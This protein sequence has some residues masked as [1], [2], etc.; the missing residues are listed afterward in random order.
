MRH[1]VKHSVLLVACLMTSMS[2]AVDK[3]KE[4][5]AQEMGKAL[6]F[7]ARL[8]F[9]N[10]ISCATCHN[11]DTAFADRRLTRAN[12]VASQGA[13]GH[14]FGDRN[15]PTASYAAFSP[16][17]HYDEKLKQYVGGQFWD[18]R[19]ETLANQ[20]GGPPVNPAEMMMPDAKAVVDRLKEVPYYKETLEAIYG[21]DVWNETDKAYRAVT[22]T[23]EAFEK[24]K[25]FSTFDSKY[26]RFLKGEYELTIEED[27]GRT[28][29]FSNNNVNC[30]TCHLINRVVEDPKETFTNFQYRNIGV[31][32]N[33]KLIEVH[34][35][36]NFVDQGLAANPNVKDKEAQRGKFKV[37]TLRN[38]AVT[39]PYMHNGVF[40]H[41]RTV[42]QFYNKY[43]DPK[44]NINPETGLP[45]APPEV[46]D[47]IALDELKAVAL[48]P[49]KIDALVAFLET[50]TDKRYEPLLEEIKKQE[51]SKK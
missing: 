16:R 24:T 38:V 6:F 46:E 51:A 15:A 33:P 34:G 17:F 42:I 4:E 7:D 1:I 2:Y 41:L 10:T 43:N 13:D 26:D 11:P 12:G 31:P 18:G 29:F 37:P 48:T 25:D 50:L 35:D 32:A 39:G 20:A 9:N 14:A 30:S 5:M 49:A 23:I 47:N 44:D 21:G 3:S 45:W 8:S 40:Q 28:L 27:L 22:E 19:A 36:P